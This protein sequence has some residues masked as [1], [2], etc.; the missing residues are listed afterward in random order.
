MKQC[1]R[2]ST[3]ELWAN[4]SWEDLNCV[5]SLG[6]T[7]VNCLQGSRENPVGSI[8]T[9]AGFPFMDKPARLDPSGTDSVTDP[10]V[11][12]FNRLIF[13]ELRSTAL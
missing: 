1:Q 9:D 11:F 12:Q 8:R 13:Q 10:S 4:F 3:D 2:I 5:S 7:W 6:K